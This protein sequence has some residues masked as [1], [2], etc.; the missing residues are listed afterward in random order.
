MGEI[1]VFAEHKGKRIKKVTYELLNKAN[2][3]AS[4]KSMG[5]GIAVLGHEM[6]FASD[7]NRYA[8]KVYIAES[9]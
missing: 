9:E 4:A 1:M 3:L 7:L 2:E 5:V 6:D 8:E